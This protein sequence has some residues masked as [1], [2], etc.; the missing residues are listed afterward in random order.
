MSASFMKK[1]EATLVVQGLCMYVVLAENC[2][3]SRLVTTLNELQ[4]C[5]G[6][7]HALKCTFI[8]GGRPECYALK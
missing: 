2:N 4:L 8:G 7:A 3:L 6:V 5:K 1:K